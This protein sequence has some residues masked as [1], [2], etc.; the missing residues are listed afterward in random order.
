METDG[1]DRYGKYYEEFNP[2]DIYKHW[3][4]RTIT[5]S[6]NELFCMLTMNHMP[7][8]IDAH[9][10][11]Q[12]QHGKILVVGLYVFSTVVGMSV[13]DTSGKTIA[14]L[15]Y[16][17]LK[18]TAP[19]FIGDTIYAETTVLDKRVTSRPDRGIIHIETK[20]TNQKG[21]TVLTFKRRFMVPV[22]DA[23]KAAS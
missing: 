14:A 9:Y 1:R 21:E 19:V 5:E 7:L 22:H 20:A 10:A 23:V 18:H 16:E 13:I 6:A 2:G 12:S 8:H 3:P 4:G 17:E 11:G 15:D